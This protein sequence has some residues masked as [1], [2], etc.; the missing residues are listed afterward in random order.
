MKRDSLA[1]LDHDIFFA[2]SL[3]PWVASF[4]ADSNGIFGNS[5]LY[6]SY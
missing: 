1:S 6:D 2:L 5:V 3:R 4:Y